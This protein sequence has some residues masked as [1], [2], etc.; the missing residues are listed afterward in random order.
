M[1]AD[2][3][4]M[5]V[6]MITEIKLM[7]RVLIL[8]Q[9]ARLALSNGL[10]DEPKYHD[11]DLILDE[12]RVPAYDLPPLLVSCEGKAITTPEEW[13]NIRRPQI[14][15]LFGNLLYGVVPAP[16]SP[17]RTTFEVVEI[18]PEFMNGSANTKASSFL[19]FAGESFAEPAWNS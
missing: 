19:I 11:K 8:L 18:G 9:I 14:L 6:E 5:P 16:E 13:F 3:A 1:Q 17:I 12:T 7:I 2:L 10:A 15:S 4:K